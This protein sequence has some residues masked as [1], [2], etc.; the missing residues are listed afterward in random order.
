[1]IHENFECEIYFIRHGESESNAL[2]D[3]TSLNP[4]SSLTSKGFVQAHLVG[5]RFRQDG[6]TFDKVYSSSLIRTVQTTQTMLAAM[7]EPNR[8]FTR[9]D[10]IVEQSTT[11]WRGIRTEDL[12]TP[13]LLAYMRTKGSHFVP[14]QGRVVPHGA[15]PLR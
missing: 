1:M 15:A 8:D 7:E 2:G 11:G 10:A 6:V 14:P 3:R 9:V 13:E 4:D 5:E 12:F